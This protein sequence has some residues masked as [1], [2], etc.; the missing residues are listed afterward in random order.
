[1]SARSFLVGVAVGLA[2]TLF[3]SLLTELVVLGI[4]VA[5]VLYLGRRRKWQTNTPSTTKTS[6]WSSP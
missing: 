2:V 1:M 6:P 3:T 5:G 4:V